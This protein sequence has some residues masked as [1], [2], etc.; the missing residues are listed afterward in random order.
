MNDFDDV[1]Q[2]E[3]DA[4]T[5]L[6]TAHDE[7]AAAVKQAKE[8]QQEKL[9]QEEAKLAA[10]AAEATAKEQERVAAL[11]A[12]ITQEIRSQVAVIE[13]RF[14]SKK[15]DIKTSVKQYFQ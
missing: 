3:K 13:Q 14:V 4:D 1:L 2:A 5:T 10:E 15:D 6:T 7:V 11:A 9:Q 12:G 8:T